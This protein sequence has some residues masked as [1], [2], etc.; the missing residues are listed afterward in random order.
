[1]K[2]A[3][4]HSTA[5]VKRRDTEKM[6]AGPCALTCECSATTTRRSCV[7]LTRWP[8][9]ALAQRL[10][11]LNNRSAKERKGLVS[12]HREDQPGA[13]PVTEATLGPRY[14]VQ[15]DYTA[16]LFLRTSRIQHAY[17]RAELAAWFTEHRRYRNS[18]YVRLVTRLTNSWL[19]HWGVRS[20][21]P[22]DDAVT[23][24]RGA[25]AILLRWRPFFVLR[26][27]SHICCV[28]KNARFITPSVPV[29][30]SAPPSGRGLAA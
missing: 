10:D 27:R 11:R 9:F 3:A 18:P 24:E 17:E 12:R 8:E 5:Q 16:A 19:A 2:T 21:M 6:A 13:R 20:A 28:P 29:L 23:T 15:V 4:R 7:S 22:S 25:P 14:G 26:R 1:M 30:K